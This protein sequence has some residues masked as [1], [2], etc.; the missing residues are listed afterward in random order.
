MTETVPRVQPAL[1]RGALYFVFQWPDAVANASLNV[2][3]GLELESA[4]TGMPS[5][6]KTMTE[7]KIVASRRTCN[8]CRCRFGAV[9]NDVQ[10]CEGF[11]RRHRAAIRLGFSRGRFGPRIGTDQDS[12]C[13][14]T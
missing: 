1:A 11:V 12:R 3:W 14:T 9:D 8:E 13:G 5:R 6:V 4:N 10:R 2:D 7:Q